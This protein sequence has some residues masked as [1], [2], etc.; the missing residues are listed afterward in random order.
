MPSLGHME[1]LTPG[2]RT[3]TLQ[4]H[5]K[6][7][8]Q[9]QNEHFFPIRNFE[10]YMFSFCHASMKNEKCHDELHPLG[11][12]LQ[13]VILRLGHIQGVVE[14]E[15]NEEGRSCRS[16]IASQASISSQAYCKHRIECD[17]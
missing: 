15:S 1:K 4:Q 14:L 13:I 17:G 2:K 7:I 10:N 16:A 12:N 8:A 6:V 11:N 9:R 3:S 5:W